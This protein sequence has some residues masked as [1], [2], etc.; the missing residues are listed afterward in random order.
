LD[1]DPLVTALPN[2]VHCV[3]K[4]WC[5]I[6]VQKVCPKKKY[7]WV[8]TVWKLSLELKVSTKQIDVNES[9]KN[10]VTV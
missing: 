10:E 7:V 8:I 4:D 2:T 9:S 6:I 3:G 5:K 1:Q